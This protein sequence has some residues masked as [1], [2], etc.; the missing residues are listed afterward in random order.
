MVVVATAVD[1]DE[2]PA[3]IA[4]LYVLPDGPYANR[5][6]IDLWP[7]SRD[8]RLYSGP[9]PTV[10]HPPC[11]RWGRYWS[12]GPSAKV[13]RKLGDDDGCF[14]AAL[15]AVRRWGGVIEHPEASYAWSMF[16]LPKPPRE[17]GWIRGLC[18]GWSCCVEQG[19]YGHRARKATWLY[20]VGSN[21]PP[22]L[23]WGKAE[24]KDRIDLGFHSTEERRR[25]VRTGI[26]QQL[27]KRQ[28]TITPPEFA[29]LLIKLVGMSA[30]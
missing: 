25:Y 16:K 13:R 30:L 23:M 4:A 6:D 17:G 24:S 12:G 9:Y 29:D 28:R 11:A 21:R 7:E 8:A 20:F 26:C 5:L 10:C 14:E 3:M 1:A 19:H 22:E 2:P 15:G 27:S 18:G